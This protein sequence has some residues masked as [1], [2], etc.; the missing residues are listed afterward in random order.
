[1]ISLLTIFFQY[2]R[3]SLMHKVKTTKSA[4]FKNGIMKFLSGSSYTIITMDALINFIIIGTVST[5][6]V[7]RV[8]ASSCYLSNVLKYLVINVKLLAIVITSYC[9][10]FRA[11]QFGTTWELFKHRKEKY[12]YLHYPLY[13][14]I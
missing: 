14:M 4:I 11:S 9:Y 12:F 10:Y 13:Q 1:M 7:S 2:F 5:L 3:I 8:Y 6:V